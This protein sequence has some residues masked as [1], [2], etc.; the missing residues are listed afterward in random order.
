VKQYEEDFAALAEEDQVGPFVV[1]C[2]AWDILEE[3]LDLNVIDKWGDFEESRKEFEDAL[4]EAIREYGFEGNRR[5]MYE[6]YTG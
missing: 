2:R 1:V 4:A 3:K 6:K 5:L